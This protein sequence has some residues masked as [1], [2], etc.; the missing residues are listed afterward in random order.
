M[1]Q[2]FDEKRQEIDLKRLAQFKQ[3]KRKDTPALGPDPAVQVQ[4]RAT[5]GLRF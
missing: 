2:P 4:Y 1:S 5:L 3:Y